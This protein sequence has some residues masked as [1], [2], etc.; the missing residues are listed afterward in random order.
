MQKEIYYEGLA[1]IVIE[2]E[3]FHGFAIQ[4]L[5]AQESWWYSSYPNPKALKSRGGNSANPGLSLK[6][7]DPGV[8]MY[9]GSRR[10]SQLKCTANVPSSAFLFFAG[11]QT[12]EWCLLA[13]VR[14]ICFTEFTVQMLISSRNTLKGTSETMFHL[15]PIN[16]DYQI[17]FFLIFHSHFLASCMW[18]SSIKNILFHFIIILH[19]GALY[20]PSV[21]AQSVLNLI[22][23]QLLVQ[24]K[25]G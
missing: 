12:V 23:K 9:D 19:F 5:E 17:I 8:P 11:H 24:E 18:G 10:T 1:P 16:Q 3:K 22:F 25:W 21:N 15:L 4:E 20:F 14:T 2:A 13:S 7:L 6:T